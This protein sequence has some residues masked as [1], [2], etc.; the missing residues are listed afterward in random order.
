V[1]HPRKKEVLSVKKKWLY[2]ILPAVTLALELL[3][4]GAVLNFA[5]PEGAPR[6]ATYSYFALTPFGY[7]HGTP[8]LTAVCTCA[9]L[10]FLILYAVTNRSTLAAAARFTLYAATV[11]SMGFLL[12]GWEYASAVGILISISLAAEAVLLSVTMKISKER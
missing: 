6:R 4:Y 8:L 10:A 1:F 2:L 11:L 9:A 12:Y 3:P 7:A 5:N